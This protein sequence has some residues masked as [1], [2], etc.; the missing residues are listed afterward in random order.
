MN[1]TLR[2][3][4]IRAGAAVVFVVALVWLMQALQSVTTM[5]MVAF[6]L[7]YILNPVVQR[8]NAWGLSR[9]LSSF[10]MLL[11]GFSAFVGFLLVVVP[12]VLGEIARFA[13]HAP[14]YWAT[15]QALAL[16][17]ATKLNIEIPQ[18]WQELA[19]LIFQQAKRI[20]PGLADSIA[21]IV[22]SLF[23]STV[24][25]VSTAFYVLLVPIIA[26]YL[27]VS[28][29]DIKQGVRDLI[30]PYARPPIVEKLT[31]IDGVL[32]AFIRGQLTVAT[33]MGILYSIGFL[34]IGIDLGLFLGITSGLLWI[35]P[36]L[37][38]MFG[39]LAGCSVALAKY[40]DLVHV[41][42]VLAWIGVVQLVESYLLTPRIV[43]HAV[44]L[45][46]VVYILALIVGANLFGFAGL[47]V[48]IPVTAVL[49]V[50]LVTAVTA[51]RNSYLYRDVGSPESP[52]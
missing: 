44:G 5:M 8:L 12:A 13:G 6:I 48:A 35:I 51:Y 18:D 33:I 45:H 22:A 36:Y 49:K 7:A 15:L 42:Y 3:T 24:H 4:L 23:K 20:L 11:L 38:T 52:S 27:M 14:K 1:E 50:L 40:G 31:E 43:G 28:F 21:R 16:E 17:A 37:G 29:E 34:L 26:Y 19:Q 32:A 9:S 41:L 30:P 2:R 47:L 39:I 46:P 10:L 25:I